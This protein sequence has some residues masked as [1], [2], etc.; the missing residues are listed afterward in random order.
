MINASQETVYSAECD[1]CKKQFE[2]SFEGW[3][4]FFHKEQI[5][6]RMPYQDWHIGDGEQGEQDKC[7]CHDCYHIDDEDVF[8][9]NKEETK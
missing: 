9:L 1:V 3:T 5:T 2:H 4:T 6:E 8:H 7:Y